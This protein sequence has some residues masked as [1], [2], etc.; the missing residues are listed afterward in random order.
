MTR[1]LSFP[2]CCGSC[3]DQAELEFLRRETMTAA[4]STVSLASAVSSIPRPLGVARQEAAASE[5][6]PTEAPSGSNPSVS[7]RLADRFSE[8]GS[9]GVCAAPLDAAALLQM[10]S[11][12]LMASVP[13][14]SA[15]HA[16]EPIGNAV[17]SPVVA[18]ASRFPTPPSLPDL[19]CRGATSGAS[20]PSFAMA[21]EPGGSESPMELRSLPE[22]SFG[23]FP[24]AL[25]ASECPSDSESLAAA[26]AEDN[27]ALSRDRPYWN[28][29]TE[30][31]TLPSAI[32]AESHS[33]NRK[34]S[35]TSYAFCL[36]L[37]YEF[38]QRANAP[39]PRRRRRRHHTV[40][41]PGPPETTRGRKTTS[42]FGSSID[43]LPRWRNTWQGT[44][45]HLAAQSLRRPRSRDLQPQR[46][47]WTRA[48]EWI[49]RRP[50][51]A[52]RPFRDTHT[53]RAAPLRSTARQQ[54]GP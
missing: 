47:D 4:Q 20:A 35:R 38:A 2:S 1:S 39:S 52:A 32:G 30:T 9:P 24:G 21:D 12:A 13:K 26:S 46:V 31:G 23:P 44:A 48:R 3:G 6:G 5:A 41:S 45:R 17:E 7:V 10:P 51:S 40:T 29:G 54:C 43:A 37:R 42:R 18:Q 25:G 15:S 33:S 34:S 16:S 28:Q 36:F 49:G 53:A 19:L 27:E 8:A 50:A 11:G 14:S 22:Y